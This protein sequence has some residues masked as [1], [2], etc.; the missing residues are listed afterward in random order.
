MK[1]SILFSFVKSKIHFF[2]DF[3]QHR[4]FQRLRYRAQWDTNIPRFSILSS[5][6]PKKI[7][8]FAKNASLESELMEWCR[9]NKAY[10]A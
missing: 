5:P 8:D 4:T 10:S 7:R 3:F 6:V 9:K 2:Q 1:Y